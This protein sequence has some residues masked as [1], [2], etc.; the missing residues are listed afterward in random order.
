MTVWD[1]A[2]LLC[3]ADK[4]E[5]LAAERTE[6]RLRR[7]CQRL[8]GV[9]SAPIEKLERAFDLLAFRNAKPGALQSD[10]IDAEREI[11]LSRE[12]ERRDI[13]AERGIAL[14][15]YQ[16]A[17]V[18]I[19]MQRRP[20]AEK[21]TVID[22]NMSAEKAIIRDDDAV[23]DCAVMADVRS[24][25]EEIVVAD[26][27]CAPRNCAA[28]DRAIFAE[29]VPFADSDAATHDWIEIQVLRRRSDDGAV[30]DQV[31]RS[32][33]HFAFEH[34]VRLQRAAGGDCHSRADDRVGADGNIL[35][36]SRR[37]IDDRCRMNLQS[38]PASLKLKYG[39]LSS[40]GEPMM[41][42]SSSL[43]W[44]SSAPSA[45]RLVKL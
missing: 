45:R 3:I 20:A 43:I 24:D 23:S 32:D 31:L 14:R 2:S 18:H 7:F 4:G 36:D 39:S 10:E 35:R 30:P 26:D 1:N 8:P 16:P 13:F 17:D 11:A 42:W 34:N 5:E 15:H 28:M 19:L 37:R 41:M 33:L 40:A 29:N 44:S 38:T 6:F 21:G 25:H 9:E 12:D 27:G 22:T